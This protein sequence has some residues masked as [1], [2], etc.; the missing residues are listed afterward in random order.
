M[1]SDILDITGAILAMKDGLVVSDFSYNKYKLNNNIVVVK[2]ENSRC[3]LT[4]KDFIELYKEKKFIILDDE[5][6]EIDAIKDEEYYS[7]KHK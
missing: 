2:S 7:F 6:C 3:K 4:L 5:S 1:K